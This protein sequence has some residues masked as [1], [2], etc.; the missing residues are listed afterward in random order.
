MG[1]TSIYKSEEGAAQVE[2]KV[3]E[4]LRL[5][6]LEKNE[7]QLETR[8]GRTNVTACGQPGN[9]PLLLFHPENINSVYWLDQVQTYAHSH[10]VY[11]VDI[12]GEPGR[13]ASL[14]PKLRGP[15]WQEWIEDIFDQ[16]N[17]HRAAL[18]GASFGAWLCLKFACSCP[19]RVER[20]ALI[21]PPG[22]VR[23]RRSRSRIV[24]SASTLMGPLGRSLIFR[25]Q[26]KKSGLDPRMKDILALSQRKL[27][28]RPAQM[29]RFSDRDLGQL[30][31]PVLLVVGGRDAFFNTDRLVL[32]AV[33]TMPQVEINYRNREGHFVSEFTREIDRFLISHYAP[34]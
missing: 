4:L 28:S 25:S 9:P 12:P 29:P 20:L 16:L 13:S 30:Y 7:L 8:H 2:A 33:K 26:L 32:R 19:E 5:W 3:R 6:P 31:C 14:Q 10:R 11:A 21:A 1:T 22:I 27:K 24:G 18:V 15:A 34:D 23:R 17:I